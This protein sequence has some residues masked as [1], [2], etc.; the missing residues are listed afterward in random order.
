MGSN[1]AMMQKMLKGPARLLLIAFVVSPALTLGIKAEAP[2]VTNRP[3]LGN[4]SADTAR[5]RAGTEIYLHQGIERW[6]LNE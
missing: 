2:R 6:G 5:P 4:R 1:P 3:P